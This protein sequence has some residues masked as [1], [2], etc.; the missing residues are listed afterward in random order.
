[1]LE[2]HEV[3]PETALAVTAEWDSLAHMRLVLALEAALSRELV[4][5]EVLAASDFEAVAQ[6]L[7]GAV[8]VG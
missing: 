5:E 2:L 7:A 8:P 3:G 6:L 4:I 1:M